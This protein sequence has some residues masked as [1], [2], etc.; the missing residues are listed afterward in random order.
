M[1][2]VN[3]ALQIGRSA[4]QTYQSALQVIG[5]NISNAGNPDYARQTAGLSAI[6][7]TNLPQGMQPGA[8]VAFTDLKRNLDESLE[9][10]IRAAIGDL[11]SAVARQ[12]SLGRVEAFFDE[13]SGEGI[14]TKLTEFFN[15]FSNVQNDP[16]DIS[17]RDITLV[18]GADLASSLAR[19]RGSLKALGDEFDGQIDTLVTD[20]DQMAGQIAELNA[21]IA[22]AEAGGRAPAGALR[23]QRDALLR[24][25]AELFAVTVREQADGSINVYIGSEPLIQGGVSRGLTTEQVVD[26]DFART[27]VQFADDGSPAPVQ[28]GQLEGL[29]T[30]R[31]QEAYGRLADLDELAAAII[32][33]V[34]RVHADGQGLSGFTS[35]T[36]TYAMDDTT[37]ALNGSE[38]G[39]SFAPRNGSFFIAV[40][41]DP[42]GT[43]VAYQ[44][45]VDLDGTADDTTLE[46][47]VA[48][49]NATVEGVT[50]GIAAGNRLQIEA[51]SGFSFTFGHDGERFREDTS[52][53][54][55]ALGINTFFDGLS[56]ADIQVNELLTAFPSLLAAAT[57]NLDGD[58]SNAGRL[59]GVGQ[60][61]SDQLGGSSVT[62]Y[63]ARMANAV[64]VAGGSALDDV[65]ADDAVLSALQ[66]Q[67]ESISGVNLD[68]EA[69]QLLK[70]ERAYQG[71]ARYVTTVDRLLMELISLVR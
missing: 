59:A 60:A 63:Y 30:A 3:G 67:K 54:L 32:F 11:E 9:N 18:A 55:A 16:S 64:A 20:A 6:P 47:L 69:L 42:T 51:D 57:V 13:V 50:A 41:D 35:V 68:E 28:G 22:V 14:S 34:N 27:A 33:E 52:N 17:L 71:A 40:A 8:G 29:I 66:L 46:S 58:G 24:D 26:G 4:L 48:D 12:Q 56:A 1:G 10:R 62:E 49:I 43:V 65:E 39:L 36:G 7:G 21:E 19:L 31:D 37:A 15:S 5:N 25:L 2:L 61:A 45:E 38:A 70:F 23:D 44:I 53:V